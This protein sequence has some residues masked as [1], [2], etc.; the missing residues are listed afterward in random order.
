[1]V[2]SLDTMMH[3]TKVNFWLHNRIDSKVDGGCSFG[4]STFQE[5]TILVNYSAPYMRAVT[6]MAT[7]QP[8]ATKILVWSF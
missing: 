1:M 4:V 2:V 6:S 3:V 8:I 5:I 7:M